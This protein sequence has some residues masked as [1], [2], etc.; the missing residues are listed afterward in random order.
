[1][2]SNWATRVRISS[3]VLPAIRAWSM[4]RTS[5]SGQPTE[6]HPR[7]TGRVN[8]QFWMPS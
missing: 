7:R 8:R 4:A 6:R 3:S 1:M 2:V 5:A